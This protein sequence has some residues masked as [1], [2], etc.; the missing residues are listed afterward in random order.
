MKNLQNTRHSD[1]IIYKSY[2]TYVLSGTRGKWRLSIL[3]LFYFI[4]EKKVEAFSSFINYNWRGFSTD[5]QKNVAA[6]CIAT[7]FSH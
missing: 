1:L 2:A 6:H 4:K 3:F 5:L 7:R